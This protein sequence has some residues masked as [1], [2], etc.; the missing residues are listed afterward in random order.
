MLQFIKEHNGTVIFMGG[1]DILKDEIKMAHNLG[2]DFHLMRGPEGASNE[3][4]LALPS[5]SFVGAGDLISR[6]GQRHESLFKSTSNSAPKINHGSAA[7]CLS[8]F[9]K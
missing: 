4:A 5:R 9:L 2:V 8:F 7:S 3:A 1:G 6:L